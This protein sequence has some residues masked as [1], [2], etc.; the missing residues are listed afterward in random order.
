[1][2]Y[3]RR[4]YNFRAATSEVLFVLEKGEE[5]DVQGQTLK[6]E[7]LLRA[8]PAWSKIVHRCPGDWFQAEARGQ[9]GFICSLGV[10]DTPPELEAPEAAEP[11]SDEPGGIKLPALVKTP[12]FWA[13]LAVTGAVLFGAGVWIGGKYGKV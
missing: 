3:A 4:R 5:I 11:R 6:S 12:L 7:F 1:M 10:S 13:T 2:A 8:N 9:E